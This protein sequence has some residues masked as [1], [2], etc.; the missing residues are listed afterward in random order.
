LASTPT[1]DQIHDDVLGAMNAPGKPYF[2]V[3]ALLA[4]GAGL[5]MV[6]WVAQMKIGMGLAG[7][8]HPVGWGFYIVNFVFWVGIAHSGTLISAVLHLVRA[9][10]RTAIARSAEAMTVFAVMTAGLFP[11]IH[12]GRFWVMYYILPYPSERQLWPNFTSPLLWD[13]VAIGTY[14]TVSSVF[15]FVGLIPDIAAA[16]DRYEQELGPNHIRTRI[17]RALAL[18]WCGAASQWRHYGRSYLFFAALATPLVIS[19]HSVVSWDF[20]VSLLPGWHTTIFPPYFVAGAIHSGLAMV[21]TL[22]IPMR[23][24]LGL[25]RIITM[26]HFDA[27]ARTIVVTALIVGYAYIVEPFIAWYSGDIFEQQ[28]ALWRVAG[29]MSWGFWIMAACNVVIPLAFLF[30]RV[31]S[32]IPALLVISL[33]VNVGMWFERF[34][35]IVGSTAHDF[36]PHNWDSYSPALVEWVILVGSFCFFLMFFLAFAKFLPVVANSEVKEEIAHEELH[37]AE[38]TPGQGALADA[39]GATTGVVAVFGKASAF[40]EALKT[41]RASAFD[42]LETYAPMRIDA[43]DEIMN[44]GPS[45]VRLFTLAGVLLGVACGFGLALGTA[46]VNNLIVGGKPPAAIIPYCVIGFE[47]SVLF[48]ALFNF[49]GLIVT[50]R[51]GKGA[52][53]AGF[54]PEFSRD[55]FGV[56]IACEPGQLGEAQ[57]VLESTQPEKIHVVG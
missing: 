7:I 18:G 13:V 32:S 51:L 5:L 53:P 12:L 44:R 2:G 19:V 54:R 6:A 31:R 43:V 8:T 20:A 36:L 48:G 4:T 50:A 35:I 28:F 40:I 45:K 34:V 39:R 56:W 14:F 9:R 37:H 1:Y 25:E 23:K 52:V 46:G 29:S 38:V 57:Q 11:L 49:I 26:R 16:R 33:L 15:F 17:Y 41:V 42:R 30:R 3:L 22:L 27:V 24:I 10:W 47:C 21:L 55:R